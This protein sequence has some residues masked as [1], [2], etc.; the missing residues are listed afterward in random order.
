ML[1]SEP[2]EEFNRIKNEIRKNYSM[3]II[4]HDK[5]AIKLIG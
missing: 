2:K 1:W 4:V 3:D 5:W